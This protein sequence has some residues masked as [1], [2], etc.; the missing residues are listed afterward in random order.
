MKLLLLINNWQKIGSLIVYDMD[1]QKIIKAS[2]TFPED[3]DS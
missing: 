1:M 2:A 3:N